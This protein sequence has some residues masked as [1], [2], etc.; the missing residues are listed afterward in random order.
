MLDIMMSV[1]KV[2]VILRF[3]VTNIKIAV[4]MLDI[5]MPRVVALVIL[6]LGM[7]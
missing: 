1:V 7:A 5:M 6:W 3:S 4:S 2:L